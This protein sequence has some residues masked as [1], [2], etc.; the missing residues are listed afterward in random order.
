MYNNKAAALEPSTGFSIST[1]WVSP[2]LVAPIQAGSSCAG[3][4]PPRPASPSQRGCFQS[5]R[6]PFAAILLC[7]QINEFTIAHTKTDIVCLLLCYTQQSG[8]L[9]KWL[10][11]VY[12]LWRQEGWL[13]G[14]SRGSWQ[15]EC[16]SVPVGGTFFPR[17]GNWQHK[18]SL[19]SLTTHLPSAGWQIPFAGF[20]SSIAGA[21]VSQ[22]IFTKI[23]K[24]RVSSEMTQS[25]D[26][27]KSFKWLKWS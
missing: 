24:Q 13:W 3:D 19:F 22:D 12:H 23:W 14:N 18:H 15:A 20:P 10:L 21:Q 26:D 1:P 8:L 16:W 2:A 11:A 9:S 25:E 7:F 17:A 6:S 27:M 5:P 4:P